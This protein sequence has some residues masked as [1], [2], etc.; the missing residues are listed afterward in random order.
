MTDMKEVADQ[1]N[2]LRER[3][4]PYLFF[5]HDDEARCHISEGYEK[6]DEELYAR[7]APIISAATPAADQI[8]IVEAAREK[9]KCSIISPA[10]SP[11]WWRQQIPWPHTQ[12]IWW[13]CRNQIA[14]AIEAFNVE[15]CE[16]YDRYCRA[17]EAGTAFDDPKP[18]AD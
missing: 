1:L 7:L 14:A 2:K 12:R 13:R 11:H 15:R 3:A 9:R 18:M 4:A 10:V 8:E 6:N 16:M 5:T 17:C